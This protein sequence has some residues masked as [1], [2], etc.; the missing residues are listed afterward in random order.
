M[1]DSEQGIQR[2]TSKIIHK[3]MCL[4]FPERIEKEETAEMEVLKQK[5]HESV[6]VVFILDFSDT[7]YITHNSIRS[8]A[9]VKAEG[10]KKGNVFVLITD[11]K[12]HQKLMDAGILRENELFKE[13]AH[14]ANMLKNME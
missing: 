10:R 14:L 3:A 12:I 13:K 6:A 1:Q 11:P 9:Q 8:I 4:K 7:V 5:I 2:I